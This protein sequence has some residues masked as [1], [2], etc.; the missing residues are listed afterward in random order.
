MNP[1]ADA[2]R[3]FIGQSTAPL[4]AASVLAVGPEHHPVLA[5]LCQ[6][7]PPRCLQPHKPAATALA[8]AGYPLV[9]ETQLDAEPKARLGVLFAGKHRGENLYYLARLADWLAVDGHWLAVCPNALGAA[10]LEKRAGELFSLAGR[11]AKRHCRVFWGPVAG[12]EPTLAAQYRALARQPV[13]GTP[14][15]SHVGAFS[16]REVDPG[17]RQLADALPPL[18]GRGADWGAGYGYL[19]YRLLTGSH[20]L[21]ALHLL[22]ADARQLA[23][24][25]ENLAPLAAD[26]A[27][28]FHWSDV[29][30]DSPQAAFD[31]IVTN[32]PFHRGKAAEPTLGQGFIK[33]AAAALRPGGT[34]YLVA[35]RQLPYEPTLQRHFP[36]LDVLASDNRYKSIAARRR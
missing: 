25:R 19:S 10:S 31:W 26:V 5:D 22:E 29:T 20:R 27:L 16:A 32:P 28:Q 14:L 33:A 24:A 2:L 36:H 13:A 15:V 4:P 21:E 3:A 8:A 30:V 7:Q 1:A 34:L 17:S 6:G 18:V 35:N 9:G 23:A 12:F 11:Y